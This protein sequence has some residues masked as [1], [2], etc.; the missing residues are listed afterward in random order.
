MFEFQFNEL[1]TNPF[2]IK[3]RDCFDRISKFIHTYKKGNDFE[4]NGIRCA[5]SIDQIQLSNGYSL[6]DFCKDHR[7]MGQLLIGIFRY[8]FI[9]DDSDEADNYMSNDY[10]I[11]KDDKDLKVHGLAAS[12]IYNTIGIG[13]LSENFWEQFVHTIEIRGKDNTTAKVYCATKFEHFETEEF[14]NWYLNQ[15]EVELIEDPTPATSKFISL[16]NDHGKNILSHF[17][18]RLLKSPYVTRVIN[19]LPYNPKVKRFIKAVYDD[20]K[21]EI[22]LTDTDK[23]FGMI[24]QSTGRN[25]RETNLIAELLERK[26][27]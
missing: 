2:C 21:I 25:S 15:S 16:R 24:I 11:K 20:G 3:G 14:Q 9:D 4:F 26:F 22:V 19:S 12:Y 13:F 10:I 6:L 17:A 27:G 5:I 23:G 18:S 1:S 7:T 8:P